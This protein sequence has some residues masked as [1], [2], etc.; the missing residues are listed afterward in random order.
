M[1]WKHFTE[2]P[3]VRHHAQQLQLLRESGK[4]FSDVVDEHGHQYVDLVMEGGGVL[5]LALV[6]YTYGLE[7]AGIRFR[8]T[9]GTSAGSINALFIQ[10]AGAPFEAKSQKLT[11]LVASMPMDKFQDGGKDGIAFVNAWLNSSPL[12]WL[13]IIPVID[14]F[15]RLGLN[16]GDAF[17]HWVTEQLT[18]FNATTWQA[19]KS[20]MNMPVPG[21]VFQN[22]SDP[23]SPPMSIPDERWRPELKI[24][25]AE[26][27]TTTKIVLPERDGLLFYSDI[28]ATNPA[29]F[30]RASMSVPFFFEPYRLTDIPNGEHIAKAWL[31][32]GYNGVVPNEA[33]FVDGGMISNFPINLFHR[34][35][36]IPR[37]PTFGAKLGIDKDNLR[38][39]DS[40]PSFAGAMIDTM[41]HDSD[42]EFIRKNPDYNQLVQEI[43]TGAH[44]WLNFSMSNNDKLD[45]FARGVA[46]AHHFLQSF[47]WAAY[48]EIR[49]NNT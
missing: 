15:L 33:A 38:T 19:L 22:S 46:A 6:G 14:D 30:V 34:A 5:G 20:T 36:H 8:S 29:D 44:H 35:K 10:A 13:T 25:T 40:L 45:L 24:V 16:P 18:S 7:Q 32:R 43:D 48:K 27:T 47:D 28:N 23:T 11:E 12:K 41:R 3:N 42:E 17:H 21:L 49:A 2:Q 31:K 39:I 26:L 37:L 4:R 1:E 9:G